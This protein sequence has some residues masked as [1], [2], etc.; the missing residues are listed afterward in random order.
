MLAF[1]FVS[2]SNAQC[3]ISFEDLDKST[4][5]TF[6]EF[7]TFA[8][9]NGYSYNSKESNYMCDIE[10]MKEAHLTLYRNITDKGFNLITYIFFQK[11]SYLSYKSILETNGKFLNSNTENEI[12][13]QIYILDNKIVLLQTKTYNSINSYLVTVSNENAE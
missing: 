6:S 1:V 5:Y 13:T 8:L 4:N 11:A 2:K 10:Y 12:L 9:N 7:E 3:L